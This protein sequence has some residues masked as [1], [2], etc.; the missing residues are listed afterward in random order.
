MDSRLL[1]RPMASSQLSPP[2]ARP[3]VLVA[4]RPALQCPLGSCK[5]PLLLCLL[6]GC[7]WTCAPACRAAIFPR[8]PHY[9]KLEILD[10]FAEPSLC[11]QRP[12]DKH[13]ELPPRAPLSPSLHTCPLL[14]VFHPAPP[15]NSSTP[16][17]A[18]GAQQS[19]SFRPWSSGPVCLR[20]RPLQ[21]W[22]AP[23]L[24]S[25]PL[26]LRPP[27]LPCSSSSLELVWAARYN[28]SQLV[29]CFLE[30]LMLLLPASRE[31]LRLQSSVPRASGVLSAPLPL[32]AVFV[33]H[34]QLTSKLPACFSDILLSKPSQSL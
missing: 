17:A 32:P 34:T 33:Q 6:L 1:G 19:P 14:A 10:N 15:G 31:I 24:T 5:A 12:T 3:G 23:P 9:W 26:D 11:C 28:T 30:F 2:R 4:S 25:C 21:A 27:S 29:P 13:R 16:V 7:R 8:V 18:P 20:P 22:W